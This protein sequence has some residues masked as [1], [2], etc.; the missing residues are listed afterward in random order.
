MITLKNIHEI[1]KIMSLQQY[2]NPSLY[3]ISLHL[4]LVGTSILNWYV[5]SKNNNYKIYKIS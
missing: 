1:M 2:L 3:K 5:M 4:V